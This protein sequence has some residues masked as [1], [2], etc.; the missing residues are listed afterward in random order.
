MKKKVR[1]T[2]LSKKKKAQVVL[3]L[4]SMKPFSKQHKLIMKFVDKC[5]PENLQRLFYDNYSYLDFISENRKR[6]QRALLIS[7]SS[8]FYKTNNTKPNLIR[9]FNNLVSYVRKYKKAL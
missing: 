8:L 5:L 6:L 7:V 1:F 3:Y 2:D 9:T 4:Y